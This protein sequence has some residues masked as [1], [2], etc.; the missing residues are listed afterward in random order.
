MEGLRRDCSSMYNFGIIWGTALPREQRHS[1][2]KISV[3]S[4]PTNQMLALVLLASTAH[5]LGSQSS[6]LQNMHACVPSLS[7]DSFHHLEAV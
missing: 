6:V 3:S 2:G 1:R 5:V 4:V 7:T